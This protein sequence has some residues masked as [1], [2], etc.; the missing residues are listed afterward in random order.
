MTTSKP[1]RLFSGLRDLEIFDCE[2]ELCGIADDVELEGAPGGPL[3]VKALL[4]GPGAF[5][6]R[7]P[8]GL[9]WTVRLIAGD[10]VARIPWRAVEHV[11]S[12]I[13]LRESAAGLGL[14]GLDRKLRPLM[15]KV[16]RG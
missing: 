4:V 3:R 13:R 12:R 7:L 15:K 6:A 5:A 9:G 11:T 16:P 8:R 14:A 2:D 10:H 1:I